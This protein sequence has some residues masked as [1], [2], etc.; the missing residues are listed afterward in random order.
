MT[1]ISKTISLRNP[2]DRLEVF[3]SHLWVDLSSFIFF[4]SRFLVSAELASHDITA[5][6]TSGH[7]ILRSTACYSG[8]P[9]NLSKLEVR[10]DMERLVIAGHMVIWTFVKSSQLLHRLKEL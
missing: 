7:L 6:V 3:D 5:F 8:A 2:L 4:A 10:I 9:W 1:I